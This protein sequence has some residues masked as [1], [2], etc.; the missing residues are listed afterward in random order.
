MAVDYKVPDK[1]K[2]PPTTHV[3]VRDPAEIAAINRKKQ[4]LT[5]P[6]GKFDPKLGEWVA[7][8]DS[9]NQH[10]GKPYKDHA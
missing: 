2:P 9:L 4:I 7:T 5:D 10:R 6:H 1:P 8:R 3:V